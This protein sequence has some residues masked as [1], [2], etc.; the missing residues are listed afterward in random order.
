MQLVDD[1]VMDHQKVDLDNNDVQ[2]TVYTSLLYTSMPSWSTEKPETF[3][4]RRREVECI[5]L[6]DSHYVQEKKR[7]ARQSPR[8]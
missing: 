8:P 2:V 3:P 5:I 1:L 7:E 4:S 6:P